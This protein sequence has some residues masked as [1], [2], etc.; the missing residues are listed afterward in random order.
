[1]SEGWV[2]LTNVANDI[3]FEIMAGLLRTGDIPSIK[4]YKDADSYLV[5]FT[6]TPIMNG[7]DV[8]VP[9]DEEEMP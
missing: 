5:V 8:L 2:V 4:K 7:I 9:E 1:M 3:E 6:G